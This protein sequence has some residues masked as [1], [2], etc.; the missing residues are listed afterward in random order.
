MASRVQTEA[1]PRP[2]IT[3]PNGPAGQVDAEAARRTGPQAPIRRRRR[4]P[5]KLLLGLLAAVALTAATIV[6]YRFWYDSVHFVSTDN[7]QISGRLVQV[8]TLT[9]GRVSSLPYDVGA[10]VDKDQVVA[11]VS[12]PVAVGTTS[13]GA[14]RFEFRGTNDELVGVRSPV[15]GVV[16][17]QAATVGDTVPAGQSLL[18][19]VDPQQ[20]WVTANVDENLVRR[21][22]PGQR[23]TVHVD[24][25]DLDQEGRVLAI[26]PASAATFSLLPTQNYSGNFT[27]VTQLVPVKIELE[28][29]DPRLMVGTSVEVKIRVQE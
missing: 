29:P 2:A 16:V 23:V 12:A 14:S 8:G 17:A 25:L 3:R 15:S 7:A 11:T 13:N 26:T 20:L 28:R 24:T 10:R 9:A 27:K 19:V 4:P 1:P 21:V 6:G 5:R 18:T 22:Q